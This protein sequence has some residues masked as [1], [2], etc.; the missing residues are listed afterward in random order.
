M[1]PTHGAFAEF[2]HTYAALPERF[3]VRVPPTPVAAPALIAFNDDLASEIGVD[4]SQLSDASLA[5]ICAGNSV[6][7]GALPLAMAYAGHQFGS[8]VPQLGDGRALLIG[9]VVDLQG[10]RRDLQW[11]GAGP[12]PFSRRGDG[13]AALGPVLREYLVSEAMHALGL[14]TTRALSAATTGESVLRE[15]GPLPG[16]VLIRVAASHVRIGTFEFFAARGDVDAVRALADYAIARH[17]PQLRDDPD[18]Y[19]ALFE[20]VAERQSSL[21][22]RWMEIGFI[23]GVMNTDNMTISGETIDFG[24]CAFMDEYDPATVYSFIDRRGRYAYG[25]QP[26]ILQWNLARLAETLLPLIDADPGQA[27]ERATASLHGVPARF[28][29]HWLAGFRRKLGLGVC[30]DEGGDRAL[31]TGLLAVMQAEAADFTSTFRALAGAA[32]DD[33]ALPGA[34]LDWTHRWRERLAREPGGIAS[35]IAT[36]RRTNPVYIPR[37]HRIEEI[38]AAAVQDGDFGPFH[39]LHTVLARPFALQP[40]R[41]PYR[42][43]PLPH[44]R[45]QNTF[46]GT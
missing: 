5:A 14:P 4:R 22:A 11:K 35:G 20:A 26:D 40:D 3:H 39:T 15:G 34:F 2:S 41:D 36:M 37:N 45:V 1:P 18:R 25:N 38:I 27:I 10:K 21:I 42:T 43:P 6:P 29:R 16:G 19:F 23:H 24:P 46:C 31:V 28:D 12:T 32:T 17:Y 33:T 7:E 13:R 8:F 9:E 30:V 44:E